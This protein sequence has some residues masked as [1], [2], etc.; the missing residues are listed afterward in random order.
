LL[1]PSPMNLS[2]KF[3]FLMPEGRRSFSP[4]TRQ[5]KTPNLSPICKRDSPSLSPFL[6]RRDVP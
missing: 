2:D 6:K 5:C 3:K 1:S 4:M